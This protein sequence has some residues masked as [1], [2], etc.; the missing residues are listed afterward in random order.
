MKKHLKA[1]AV[2][3]FLSLIITGCQTGTTSSNSSSNTSSNQSSQESSSSSS[4]SSL[5]PKKYSVI[6]QNYDGL[7]LEVD[8]EVLEN[9]VPTYDGPTPEKEQDA[10]Y[11]YVFAGWTPEVTAVTDDIIYVATFNAE[12]RKYTVI[13]KDENGDVLETDTDVPYGTVPTYDSE[14]PTKESTVEHTYSFDGWSTEIVE[15]TG[16]ATYIAKYKEEARKYVIT[17]KNEDDTVI[18]T[19]EVAYGETPLYEG[20]TPEKD[21]TT[22][23]KYT[24]DGWSPNVVAVE[25]DA[26]YTAQFKEETR[27]YTVTWVNFDGEVLKVDELEYGQTPVYSGEDP[28]RPHEHGLDF[29]WKGWSPTIVP[30]Y[31]DT[32][33]TAK[34]TYKASFDF[35]LLDY[36]MNEG[37]DISELKGAPWINANLRGQLKKIKKPSLKDDFYAAINY[38][39]ILNGVP[40]PFEYDD[41]VTNWAINAVYNNSEYTTNG[42]FL[43]AAINKLAY[44]DVDVVSNYLANI[45]LNDYLSSS[46]IFASTSSYL[47]ISYQDDKYFV[48]YNDGYISGTQGLHYL[49]FLSSYYAD[50][51]NVTSSLVNKLVSAYTINVSSSD[52]NSARDLDQQLSDTIYNDRYR[53]SGT[54][55]YTVKDVPWTQMKS[56]LLDAGFEETDSI[57]INNY[58]KNALNYLFNSYAVNQ[59]SVLKND[60]VM[61]LAF[62]YRFLMGANNY[63]AFNQVLSNLSEGFFQDERGLYYYDGQELAKRMMRLSMKEP[64]EQSYLELTSSEEIKQNV[65]NLIEDVLEGYNAIINDITWLNDTTKANVLRKLNAMAYQSCYSDKRFYFSKIDTTGLESASLFDLYNRYSDTSLRDTIDKHLDSPFEYVWD[66]MTTY[67]TNAFY[68]SQGN[69]FVILNGIVPGF[70][71]ET[72]EELYGL[73][74]FVIGHEITH[75]FDANGS[76]FDENGNYKDLMTGT[77]RTKFNRKVNKM[78]SFY[79]KINLFDANFVDGDNV[80]TEATADMGGIRVMLKLAES[81]P[82]F[83]YDLFFR[84]AA[85]AWC[86]QPYSAEAA[87]YRLSDA[88]PFAYLRVNVTLAQFDEFIETYDI[89]PGD[90]MYIPEDERVAIW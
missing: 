77:D 30:V 76:Q 78:A 58:N 26:T 7:V 65:A 44:G 12:V 25:G 88:H 74:G 84:S 17:W 32:V 61:R 39:D 79:K 87:Q 15:V 10:Q 36:E 66:V 45:D 28:T 14:E 59:A 83:N 54:T 63:K 19:E 23:Y 60:L 24:F 11:D 13:W 57:S 69:V 82:D 70:Y 75:A 29:T 68:T 16:D 49:W 2:L 33:Y 73:L 71:S 1:I 48:S 35:T 55:T 56:A 42:D 5:A 38:D 80:N 51:S 81:I 86:T 27:T 64:F 90:G 3:G 40:G 4:S 62:D 6:W 43:Y 41:Q 52:L 50:I 72:V 9:T 67:T 18:K 22:Q 89:G 46:D 47:K 34:Y 37:Y 85:R 53:Y 8:E 20:D 31:R 21:P